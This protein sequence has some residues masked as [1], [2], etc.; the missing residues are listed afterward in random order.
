MSGPIINS[1][2]FNGML[3]FADI[4]ENPVVMTMQL[5][6]DV[7]LSSESGVT[8]PAKGL[9]I[10]SN[11]G[12]PLQVA[13]NGTYFQLPAIGGSLS[14]VRVEAGLDSGADDREGTQIYLALSDDLSIAGGYAEIGNDLPAPLK[15]RKGSIYGSCTI[16]R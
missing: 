12:A 14:G 10:D 15:G 5:V 16:I 1:F 3:T 2:K 11:F 7:D 9:L 8:Y 13:V 4:G 6:L